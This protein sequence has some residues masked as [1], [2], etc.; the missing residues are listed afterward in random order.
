MKHKFASLK[1]IL[2]NCI[3]ICMHV[4]DTLHEFTDASEHRSVSMFR[5][6]E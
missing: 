3:C 2:E 1:T 4:Y 6:K 5:V